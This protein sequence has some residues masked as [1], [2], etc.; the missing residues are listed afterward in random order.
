MRAQGIDVSRYNKYVRSA[1]AT[2]RID[3]VIQK[4]TEGT[5]YVDLLLE[6]IWQGVAQIPVRGG[7]H[8]QRSGMSWQAQAD[9]YLNTAARHSY[10]F[11]VD[12]LEIYS[13]AYS[14]S[15]FADTRR[16][17]DYWKQQTG[18]PVMLY[19]NGS[20]YKSFAAAIK[21]LYP[22]GQAWLDGLNFWYAWPSLIAPNPILPI[23]RTT[24]KF[25]Q[26]RWDGPL[27]EWGNGIPCDVN[28]FN[29]TPEELQAWARVVT[30]PPPT[31]GTMKGKVL[32]PYKINV[33]D[34]AG[35][36]VT[37]LVANDVVYGEVYTDN[38][39]RIRFTKI[40]RAAGNIENLVAM[41]N[42]VTTDGGARLI[43]LTNEA[44]PIPQPPPTTDK[45]TIEVYVDGVL[46]YHREL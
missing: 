3:F 18:Q 14:D 41:C 37:Q 5:A 6:E 38:R 15:M 42:A 2:Q 45:H 23:G 21:R 12:D 43:Q 19:T 29:G 27:G 8:Y 35:L 13:N 1:E 46:D 39:E 25:W 22:D 16:I 17:L 20:T 4:L 34:S 33:R 10:H 30:T 26:Y 44:E 7:Y 32:A 31:G 40:Y 9:H 28:Y 24:W 36:I 11:H